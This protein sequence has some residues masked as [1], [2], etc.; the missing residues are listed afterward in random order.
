MPRATCHIPHT[1]ATPL[2]LYSSTALL[3]YCCCSYSLLLL[4]SAAAAAAATCY[5]LPATC[6]L[7]LHY[8]YPAAAAATGCRQG[9]R[10]EDQV[11]AL[12]GPHQQRVQQR[13]EPMRVGGE[14][15]QARPR[16]AQRDERHLRHREGG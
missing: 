11:A 4:L 14:G 5:L 10:V 12:L 1:T 7:L 13:R 6:Y 16:A 8:Y 3:H 9:A 2:L 15:D